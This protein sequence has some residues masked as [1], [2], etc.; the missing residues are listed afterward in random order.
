[1]SSRIRSFEPL[2]AGVARIKDELINP[3]KLRESGDGHR[4]RGAAG[5]AGSLALSALLMTAHEPTRDSTKPS[6][7][8]S[9][10]SRAWTNAPIVS[11]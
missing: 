8:S 7:S 6:N 11:P 2:M 3:T 4:R 10:G 1:M 9:S 5:A